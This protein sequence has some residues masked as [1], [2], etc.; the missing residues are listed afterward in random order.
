MLKHCLPSNL[1]FINAVCNLLYGASISYIE[2]ILSLKKDSP[3]K[4][5]RRFSEPYLHRLVFAKSHPIE[6]PTFVSVRKYRL[7]VVGTLGF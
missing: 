6:A 7:A 3:F 5:P 2:A 1:F 4:L